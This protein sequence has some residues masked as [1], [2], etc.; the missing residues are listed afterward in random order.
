MD[1]IDPG[2]LLQGSLSQQNVYKALQKLRAFERLAAYDPVLA[3]TFPLD[4]AGPD[5]DLDILCEVRDHHGFKKD[6]AG[7]FDRES[8][9]NIKEKLINGKAV[10]IARFHFQGY[11]VEIFGQDVPVV[12]QNAY[13]HLLIEKY[14]L[15]HQLMG[16]ESRLKTLK[17]QGKSTEEA[18]ALL[19]KMEGN[20]YDGLIAY[21]KELGLYS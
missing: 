16:S 1:M 21:G 12:R 15:Q 6:V 11:P 17:Q 4:L 8:N 2:Y 20:P 14:L 18:F 19:L 10:T 3:G 13:R 7:F 5:S 9:F